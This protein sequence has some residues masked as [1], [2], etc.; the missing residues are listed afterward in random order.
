MAS[1]SRLALTLAT[2][3]QSDTLSP[4]TT[5]MVFP[6]NQQVPTALAAGQIHGGVLASATQNGWLAKL[7]SQLDVL[8]PRP[9]G[10]KGPV[11]G[12]KVHIRL[13]AINRVTGA[14]VGVLVM[15]EKRQ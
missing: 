13:I 12:D 9:Y 14:I 15:P 11:L 10:S 2:T 4:V 6:I 5:P 1:T 8:V 3:R 7:D